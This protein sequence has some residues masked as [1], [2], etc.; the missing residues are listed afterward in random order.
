MNEAGHRHGALRRSDLFGWI[1]FAATMAVLPLIFRSGFAMTMLSQMAIAIVAC[2]SFNILLGQGGMLSFGHAVYSGLGAFV[3]IHA[4][5][6]VGTGALP[7]PVSLIPLVGGIAGLAF[8]ALLGFV[9]TRRSGTPFAMITLGLGELV[10]ALV[11]MW[12]GFSGGEA[13]IS[14]NRVVGSAVLG[15]SF[16]PQVQV[17]GLLAFYAFVCSVAINAFTRTPLGRLLNAVR[18]NAERVAFVGHDPQRVRW[19]AFCIAGFFA[20]IAGGMFVLNAES[21]SSEVVGTA[22]SGA[23]LMFT[24]LGGVT[25]F[26]GPIIG[27]VLMVGASVWLAA[28]TKAWLLYFGLMF[29]AM[30]MVAPGGIASLVAANVRVARAGRL[31]ELA[32]AYATVTGAAVPMALGVAALIEMVYRLQFDDGLGSH[33]RFIGVDL[34]VGAVSAWLGASALAVFGIVVFEWARRRFARRWREVQHQID[35]KTHPRTRAA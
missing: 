5:K 18:D 17:Y 35:A 6:A 26:C 3:A 19:L 27:A 24:V 31:H 30:V 9:T 25:F 21:V 11:L 14:A 16:G 15:I 2:L 12:P 1:G 23:Y 4:L 29:I 8:A 33:L 28:L 22:R 13:G 32:G 7:I 34:D 10:A 20:G